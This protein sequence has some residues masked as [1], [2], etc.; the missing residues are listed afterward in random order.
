MAREW[1]DPS[2]YKAELGKPNAFIPA[3]ERIATAEEG[4]VEQ[5]RLITAADL[6]HT[7]A[8]RNLTLSEA[9]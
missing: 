3:S 2:R 1:E 6:P 5:D 9:T 7:A 4:R 8:V